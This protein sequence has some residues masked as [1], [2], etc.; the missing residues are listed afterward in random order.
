M[1]DDALRKLLVAQ[2][3][4]L[5]A[6]VLGHAERELYPRLS[7]DQQK[8]FRSKV[9]GAVDAYHDLMLDVLGASEDPTTL[10]NAEAIALLRDVRAQ[11]DV[12]AE[13]T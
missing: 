10:L 12:L 13:R 7:A 1:A 5:V 2:R 4:R 9:L 11:L 8:A 3:K 6:S